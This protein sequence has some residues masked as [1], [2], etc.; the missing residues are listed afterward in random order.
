MQHCRQLPTVRRDKAPKPRNDV[1]GLAIRT[2]IT[3]AEYQARKTALEAEPDAL[4][5]LLA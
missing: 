4:D 1:Q 2:R 5:A 3:E